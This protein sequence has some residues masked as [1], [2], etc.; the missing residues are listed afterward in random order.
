MQYLT[1]KFSIDI[2]H[3][4]SAG[5]GLHA[6]FSKSKINVIQNL[7]SDMLVWPNRR[8]IFK[9]L[10]NQLSSFQTQNFAIL[11]DYLNISILKY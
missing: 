5:N 7:G 3:I 8:P 9:L 2:L 10:Y 1:K 11:Q 4:V 6:L